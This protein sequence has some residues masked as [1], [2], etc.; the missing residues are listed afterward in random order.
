M[1]KP[2]GQNTT[3]KTPANRGPE[4]E[5]RRLTEV[6]LGTM[7]QPLLVLNAELRVEMAN[8]AFLRTFAVDEGETDGRLIYDLGN[9]QWDIP[10]LR[11]LLEDILPNNGP[12]DDYR[13]E[14]DF[15]QIG[16]RVMLLNA[17]RMERVD[18]PETILLAIDDIT[19]QEHARALME[20]EK[21]YVE[22][23]IDSSRDALLIL[24]FDLRVK[25]ANETFFNTFKVD[26]ADTLGRKVYELGN[27]QW[28]IPRLRD[29]LENVLPNDNA[30]D[31]YEIEHDFT[32]LGRRTMELNARRVDH[33]QLILLAIEDQ[34][35]ARRADRAIIES[36]QR[37]R[38]VIDNLF[39]FVGLLTPEGIVIE[40]NRAPLEAAGI[41][42]AD[43]QGRRFEECYWWSHSTEV[44]A[45]LRKAIQRAAQ[46]EFVRYDVEIQVAD[47]RL[48]IDFMLAPL[49]DEAGEII[50]LIPS[51]VDITER[52]RLTQ[53]RFQSFLDVVPDAVI[54]VRSDCKIHAVNDETERMFGYARSELIGQ[55]IEF[56]MP[57]RYVERH[58][59][60]QKAFFANPMRRP[61]GPELE[62]FGLTKSGREIPLEVSL[63]PKEMPDGTMA[64]AAVRDITERRQAEKVLR[65]AIKA[66]ESANALKSRFVAATSHDLRQPLQ[67]IG[68]LGAALA[69]KTRDEASRK[70]LAQLR[71]TVGAMSDI[72]NSLLDI[73]RLDT[74]QMEP[75]IANFPVQRLLAR[76]R[77]QFGYVADSR[78][79]DLRMIA[80]SAIVRSDPQLLERL[81][82]NLVSN[83]IKYTVSGGRVLVGCRRCGDILCIAVLDSGVGIPEDQL[84]RIFDEYYRLEPTS[85]LVREPGLGLG[86]ALVKRL[87]EL[88]G[89]RVRVRSTQ[90]GS[91]FAVEVPLADARGGRGELLAGQEAAPDGQPKVTVLLVDDETGPRES[92]RLLLELSGYDV[93][94]VATAR[95]ALA[96]HTHRF[97][98]RLVIAD[99]RLGQGMTGV[100]LIRSLREATG[101]DFA[102]VVMTGDSSRETRREIESANCRYELKPVKPDHLM[103]LVGQLAGQGARTASPERVPGPEVPTPAPKPARS[104]EKT[105]FLIE[106]DDEVR[107]ALRS[108]L[109]AAGHQV[110]EFVTGEAFLQAPDAL[111]R[112][113]CVVLDVGLPGMSG[114]IVQERLAD[115]RNLSVVV[116]T[117]RREVPLAVQAMRAGAVDFLEKPFDGDRLLEAVDRALQHAAQNSAAARQCETDAAA[118]EQFARLTPREREVIALVVDGLPNKEVAYKLGINQRTVES[119]RA[120]GMHKLG[121]SS[122]AELVRFA[123]AAEAAG[124]QIFPR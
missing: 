18:Q 12:V 1:P 92:L 4:G 33:I 110:E 51:A 89:H 60:H 13:V 75:E 29:L 42:F 72:L 32:G 98:P 37:L 79:L 104:T 85:G 82:G 105:V 17:H 59:A 41:T 53:E 43:V 74:G 96:I 3:D 97:P 25:S 94:A 31:N 90:R 71:E 88:M 45:Q 38:R 24:D 73:D 63:S 114:L 40:A 111:A 95:E 69:Q 55:P 80:S 115:H 34:T 22:M 120:R 64:L 76:L 81:V 106:D 30:F 77:S 15:E 93:R 65:A 14:H 123:I 118:A 5:E 39:A 121:A 27:G 61:M 26:P 109:E 44:Q 19:E 35:A 23:I 91:M 119:H 11:H 108:L 48:T 116:V 87:S 83:A 8:C 2:N 57:E 99:Y 10:E 52:N 112:K 122:L 78:G 84:N 113:G 102:A 6:I 100:G 117:G 67:T 103:N 56:L 50:G 47:G 66:A 58:E 21:E 107:G 7:R 54:L 9:G 86:L 49:R 70:I 46:G 68:L 62:I 28:N 16:R 20:G 124:A 101:W 36:E